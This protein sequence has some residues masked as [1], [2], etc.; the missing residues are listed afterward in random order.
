MTNKEITKKAREQFKNGDRAGL[1]QTVAAMN[2]KTERKHN[3]KRT[4]RFGL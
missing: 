1:R 4:G 3:A 2:A